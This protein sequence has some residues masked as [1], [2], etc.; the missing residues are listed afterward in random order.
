M[1]FLL[2]SA[3]LHSP[4]QALNQNLIPRRIILQLL[5][6]LFWLQGLLIIRSIDGGTKV[7]QDS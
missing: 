5:R 4:V 2:D 1:P 3:N 6:D 7:K